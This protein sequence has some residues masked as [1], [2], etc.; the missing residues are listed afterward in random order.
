MLDD[1][2]A[3][4]LAATEAGILPDERDDQAAGQPDSP[5]TSTTTTT[6]T[7]AAATTTT[8]APAPVWPSLPTPAA[9][10]LTDAEVVAY[11]DFAN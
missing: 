1:G 3:V 7:T 6:T 11:D 9:I 8:T 2:T 4:T 10:S 5:A